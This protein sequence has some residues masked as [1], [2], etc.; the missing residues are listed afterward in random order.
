MQIN[1]PCVL[2]AFVG[3]P[4][5]RGRVVITPSVHKRRN[6]LR[7]Y[8]LLVHGESYEYPSSLGDAMCCV[9]SFF[10]GLLYE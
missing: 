3:S 2:A 8:F 5:N 6:V 1:L 10:V 9:S 4:I 7:L